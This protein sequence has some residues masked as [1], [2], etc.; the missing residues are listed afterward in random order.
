MVKEVPGTEA[1]QPPIPQRGYARSEWRY[2]ILRLCTVLLMFLGTSCINE[3]WQTKDISGLMPPLELQLTAADGEDLSEA[4]L[5]GRVVLLVFGY[6][7]CPDICPTNLA[8]LAALKRHLPA[9]RAE[10]VQILFVSVDPQRDTPNQLAA[11]TDYF[12]ADIIGATGTPDRLRALS[13][14]YRT[15]FSYGEADADGF[16]EV[17]HSS[18]VYVFDPN[19]EVRLLFR[20]SDTVEQMAADLTRLLK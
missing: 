19:G 8:Q 13:R 6:A 9:S 3:A 16:Y 14:R 1:C 17:I 15:T 7:S 4:D 18:G 20:P 10:A 11:F 2:G 12:D 5:Q